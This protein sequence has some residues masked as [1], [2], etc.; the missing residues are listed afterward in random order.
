MCIN[1][2][3]VGRAAVAVVAMTS[4]A[5]AALD[6]RLVDAAKNRDTEAVRRLLKQ[7]VQGFGLEEAFD[8]G[9]GHH[10]HRSLFEKRREGRW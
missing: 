1:I 3:V 4:L 6:L 10:A 2:R 7:G 9:P 8:D 5:A